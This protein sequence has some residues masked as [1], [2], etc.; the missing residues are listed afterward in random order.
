MTCRNQKDHH[1]MINCSKSD[2]FMA[3]STLDHQATN[4]N[5]QKHDAFLWQSR[6][7]AIL[8]FKTHKIRAQTLFLLWISKWLSPKN[9]FLH[10]KDTS[11]TA[12]MDSFFSTPGL[13]KDLL[14]NQTIT[15][16]TINKNRKGLRKDL[17]D[18]SLMLLYKKKK[19]VFATC[20]CNKKDI[21]L[22]ST[23]HTAMTVRTGKRNRHT[24]E[25]EEKPEIALGYNKYMEG[26]DQVDLCLA[27]Y[28]FNQKTLKWWKHA[29]TH[30][31]HLARVQ[32]HILY[33]KNNNRGNRNTKSLYEFTLCPPT[34]PTG[35]CGREKR[36]ISLTT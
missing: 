2:P 8:T 4:R 16:G 10:G 15:C 32:A 17:T 24:D 33:K 25:P 14:Q 34:F 9:A 31:I 21:M 18:K 3:T 28:S 36:P 13:F 29:A 22:M 20:Y 5:L 27:L 11:N 6:V 23:S 26:V 12:Y 7:Y 19:G 35:K 30:L 1:N